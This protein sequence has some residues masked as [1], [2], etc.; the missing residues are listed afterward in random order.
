MILVV[1]V[2]A[3]VVATIVAWRSLPSARRRIWTVFILY[4]SLLPI[5]AALYYD[6]YLS[7]P[8]N[9]AFAT[10]VAETRGA[11]VNSRL[12]L[13]AAELQLEEMSSREILEALRGSAPLLIDRN[14]GT[15]HLDARKSMLTV[16]TS[17]FVTVVGDPRGDVISEVAIVRKSP[18]RRWLQS[19]MLV[20]S[21]DEHLLDYL[22]SADAR[23]Q[24]ANLISTELSRLTPTLQA[25]QDQLAQPLP[26][27]SDQWGFVGFVYFSVITQATIGYGDIIPNSRFARMIVMLQVVISVALLTV[28][29]ASAAAF[30]HGREGAA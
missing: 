25:L 5:F 11:E 10:Q 15:V 29:L 1:T 9:F 18:P 26:N 22:A 4:V 19:V 6:L 16:S 24:Y 7:A 23:R 20:G 2:G 28:V 21:R 30:I 13:A 8:D 3:A 17:T 14:G 12:R 27:R